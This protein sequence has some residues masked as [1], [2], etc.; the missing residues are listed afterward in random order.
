MQKVMPDP[1]DNYYADHR[2]PGHAEVSRSTFHTEAGLARFLDRH[3]K[4]GDL[5]VIAAGPI[6]PAVTS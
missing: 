4:A 1:F 2:L 5:D 3:A 6:C